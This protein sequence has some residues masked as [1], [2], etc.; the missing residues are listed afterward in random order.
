[1]SNP[2]QL[3]QQLNTSYTMNVEQDVQGMYA[4]IVPKEREEF[5]QELE[6]LPGEAVE[7]LEDIY[8]A[9]DRPKTIINPM[10]D[11]LEMLGQ[12][13]ANEIDQAVIHKLV[14]E[15]EEKS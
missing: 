13:I 15:N 5:E 6:G 9:A 12:G 7:L 10:I 1:M 11:L 3:N 14:T 2:V 4:D 8:D